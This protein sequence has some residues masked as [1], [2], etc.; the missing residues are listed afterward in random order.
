MPDMDD[1]VDVAVRF[2]LGFFV[3]FFI[4]GPIIIFALEHFAR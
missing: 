4:I 2:C 3:G 1:V